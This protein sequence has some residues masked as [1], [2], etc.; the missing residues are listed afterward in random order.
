MLTPGEFVMSPESVNKYGTGFMNQLNKGKMPGFRK[1]GPVY[2]QG[3]G[4][5]G[6]GG[7]SFVLGEGFN[8]SV[9][10]ISEAFTI[11]SNAVAAFEAIPKD[12]T[13]SIAPVNVTLS[14]VGAEV[15]NSLEPQLNEMVQSMI[16]NAIPQITEQVTR[17]QRGGFV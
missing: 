3:G 9:N 7:G 8:E 16:S 5:A 13:M 11:F 4:A 6:N 12:F 15:F 10:K 1:G 2:R 14:I 17:N